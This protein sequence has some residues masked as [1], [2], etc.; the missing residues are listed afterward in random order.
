MNQWGII[1]L[2]HLAHWVGERGFSPHLTH[3]SA[4]DFSLPGEWRNIKKRLVRTLWV[5]VDR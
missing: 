1:V 2:P 5:G 4:G 3:Q